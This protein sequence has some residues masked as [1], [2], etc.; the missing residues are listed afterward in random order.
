MSRLRM[1]DKISWPHCPWSG[2]AVSM[3]MPASRLCSISQVGDDEEIRHK[4]S[5]DDMLPVQKKIKNEN[6]NR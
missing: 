4:T 3:Q 5:L 6:Q 2:D 1:L